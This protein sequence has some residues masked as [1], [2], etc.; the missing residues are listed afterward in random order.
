MTKRRTPISSCPGD[1][2]RSR[3][4]R[5]PSRR[6]WGERCC[7]APQAR[8]RSERGA[9]PGT[10]AISA[11]GAGPVLGAGE[12]KGR[13][14]R[15]A[16]RRR[17]QPR[18]ARRVPAPRPALSRGAA[19][20]PRAH[21]RRGLRQDSCASTPTRRLCAT[22]ASPWAT[23][24]R[25]AAKLLSLWRDLAR[26]AAEPRPGPDP[27]PRRCGSTS[28]YRTRTASHRSLKA[29]PGE[30]D[31]VSAAAQAAALAFTAFPDAASPEAEVLALWVAD[32]ILALRLR[33]A[34]PLPLIATTILDPVSAGAS[35]RA[36]GRGRATPAW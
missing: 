28:L 17:R 22:C 1:S 30:D 21:E 35:R 15:S 6:P 3:P 26:P 23:S 8:E 34:R 27:R 10:A 31:P 19:L 2:R 13:G 9:N 14:G 7:A 11:G 4:A 36:G 33:W 32:L 29:W 25:P 18:S 16:V 5:R 24:S 20:P 12:R